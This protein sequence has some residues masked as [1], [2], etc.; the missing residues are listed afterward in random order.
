MSK[1]KLKLI[2]LLFFLGMLGV[3]SILTMEI[4]L[5]PEA[6]AK[7]LEK[8]SQEQIKMLLLL[9][10][11]F[12]LLAMVLIGGILYDK[13]GFQAPILESL[14]R[15][16]GLTNQWKSVLTSG[17]AGGIAA[18]LI[19]VG[20]SAFTYPSLP[21]EFIALGEKIKP[22]LAARFL[23]GG[24]LEEILMRFGLMTLFVWIMSKLLKRLSPGIYWSGIMLTALLFAVGHFPIAFQAVP[25]PSPA[26]LG[27]ILAGNT[28]GGVVFGWLYWKKGLESAMVA[29]IFAHVVMVLL[30]PLL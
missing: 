30:E 15:K 1:N 5:P 3:F 20:L 19:I 21:E 22:S 8:L 12:M 29:H 6:E 7:L 2:A 14:V 27:Y 11:V 26:L 28:V 24:I 9:N 10:P 16:D 23:Y 17:M 25:S 13:T 4:P 18:G